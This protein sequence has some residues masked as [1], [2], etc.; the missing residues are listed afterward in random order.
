MFV[1][2][3]KIGSKH[4]MAPV[5]KVSIHVQ[6]CLF[7]NGMNLLSNWR[8]PWTCDG[9]PRWQMISTHLNITFCWTRWWFNMN[10]PTFCFLLSFVWAK[11]VAEFGTHSGICENK[12]NLETNKWQAAVARCHKARPCTRVTRGQPKEIPVGILCNFS[13]LL[14][15]SPDCL[16]GLPSWG[17]P[18][19]WGSGPSCSSKPWLWAV[20]LLLRHFP[21]LLSAVMFLLVMGTTLVFP[22]RWCSSSAQ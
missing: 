21:S 1:Q 10:C 18:T 7:Q 16:C 2:R 3:I 15:S 22:L 17:P 4:N 12:Q 20:L 5:F 13:L 6:R 9:L 11:S 19:R 8:I 14:I